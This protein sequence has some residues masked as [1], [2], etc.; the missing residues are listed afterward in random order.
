M[1]APLVPAGTTLDSFDGQ[2]FISLV[3]FMFEDTRVLGVPVPGHREFEEVNLRCYVRRHDPESGEVKRAVVFIREFITEHFWGY[4][5]QRDGG[6]VEYQVEHPRWLAWRATDARL[7][8]AVGEYYG[9]PFADV[10]AEPSHSAFVAT[11]SDIV[12]RKPRRIA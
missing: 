3:G 5:T 12:V 9:A 1:L 7:V 11:G 4:V 10:M 6:T 8:G 2:T